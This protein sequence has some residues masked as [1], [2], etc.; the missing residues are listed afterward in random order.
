MVKEK[1]TADDWGKVRAHLHHSFYLIDDLLS[2]KERLLVQAG[3]DEGVD[4]K[5]LLQL[6]II[7]QVKVRWLSLLI[8]A[9]NAITN[10]KVSHKFQKD[11]DMEFTFL[12]L[13][14]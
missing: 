5:R 14:I 4:V 1:Y 10:V 11:T 12:I 2:G 7:R 3:D 9:D 13:A 8:H 6:L